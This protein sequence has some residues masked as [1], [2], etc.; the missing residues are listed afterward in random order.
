MTRKEKLRKYGTLLGGYGFGVFL[1][2]GINLILIPFF[3]KV[4]TPEDFGVIAITQIITLFLT[5]IYLFGASDT[6]QR[7]YYQW[8]EEERPHYLGWFFWFI[9]SFTLVLTVILDTL[10]VRYSRYVIT[11]VSFDP[12]LRYTLW[13]AFFVNFL[14]F[15][16]AISRIKQKVLTY[17]ILM[18]GSFLTQ[19]AI[20][21]YLV[22]HEKLGVYGYVRGFWIANAIW[23]IPS[24]LMTFRDAELF[25]SKKYMKIPLKFAAPLSL[26]GIF[27]G[28]STVLD[29]YFL[30]KFLPLATIGFYN[31]ARQFASLVNVINSITKL[32]FIPYIYKINAIKKNAAAVLSNFS[33]V[34]S[35]LMT[36]PVVACCTLGYEVV[37]AL[38]PTGVY[39]KLIEYIPA[40]A[41]SFYIIAVGQITGRG[42]D[43]AGTTKW[44]TLVPLAGIIVSLTV[45]LNFLPEY[46]VW[47]VLWSVLLG[48]LARSTVNIILAIKYFPRELHIAKLLSSWVVAGVFYVLLM[49]VRLESI[50]ISFAIKLMAILILAAILVRFI[51]LRNIKTL[52]HPGQPD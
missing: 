35:V 28:F 46:G 47:A 32:I 1:N 48:S 44:V 33:L 42:M 3:W 29:R 41:V 22:M 18:N 11:S 17:N 51:L 40:F 10:G 43:L 49:N 21:L 8:T 38:D 23:F 16:V 50:W 9:F 26:A 15:P 31:L 14:S 13:S 39:I 37:A 45:Y 27:E 34:Y 19:I 36:V 25:P 12:L 5:P 52:L 7:Y 4:L 6:I 24:L 30:D 2:Q 20:V